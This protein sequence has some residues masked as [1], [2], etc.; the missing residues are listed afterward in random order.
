MEEWRDLPGYPMYRV[1]SEGAVWTRKYGRR[2]S[3]SVRR[4]GYKVFT[5]SV[6]RRQVNLPVHQAVCLAFHGPRPDGA[7]VRH[8]NGDQLDNR[9]ANLAWGSPSENAQDK[10][11]HGTDRNAA[12]THCKNGHPFDVENTYVIPATG[13]RM[14]RRCRADRQARYNTAN[15]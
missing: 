14:C 6:G 10:R 1:S 3:P 8:L 9:A 12:K 11:R 7:V 4:T 5:P 13:N 15:H 2:L